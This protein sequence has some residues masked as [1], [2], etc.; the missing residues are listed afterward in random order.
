ML[1]TLVEY[2]PRAFGGNSD[3]FFN[4]L[5]RLMHSRLAMKVGGGVVP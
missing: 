1:F 3:R 4:V 2:D 5:D